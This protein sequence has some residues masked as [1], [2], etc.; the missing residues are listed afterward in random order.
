MQSDFFIKE[1][2][3]GPRGKPRL[4]AA[5]PIMV[6]G[7]PGTTAMSEWSVSPP[8]LPSSFAADRSGV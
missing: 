2:P 1:L 3:A 7:I 6:P 5:S 8:R 4:E